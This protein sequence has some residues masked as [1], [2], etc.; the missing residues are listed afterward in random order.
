M[1]TLTTLHQMGIPSLLHQVES[2]GD[3]ENQR[4]KIEKIWLECIGGLPP[5]VKTH[6]NVISWETYECYYFI[7]IEY[8][9]VFNDTVPANLLIP[10]ESNCKKISSKEGA[11]DVINSSH[12]RYPSV[13][14]LHPTS[15]SGKNDVSTKDGRQNRQYGLEL[16]NR[17]YI[18]LAPDTITAGERVRDDEKPFQTAGFDLAYPKWSAVAKML[19]D[20][21]QGISLLEH[22]NCVDSSRIGVIGHSLGGY[23]GYFLAGVD[24]RIKAVVCS[25]GFST[26]AGDPELHR[27]GKRDWF[28]H[29]PQ[30]SEYINEG[31]V[32]FEFTEIAA[33]VAPTPF[34]LWMGQ[35]DSI[36]PH[37]KSAAEGFCKLD[38]LYSWLGQKE[39][40]QTLIG[41]ASHDFPYEIRQVAYS[42]LDKWLKK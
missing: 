36:F 25:C 7:K 28:S 2:K 6:F 16:V 41:N 4:E 31:K 38:S 39:K 27:W 40:I 24:R 30:L 20:H 26:F 12:H 15:D 32:P 42:F 35:N 9:T 19:V 1:Y 29:I 33:L 34:F 22:L 14:A 10:K 8:D 5:L 21:Q 17:G 11:I 18:V 37:W 23:N 3:W 13:I